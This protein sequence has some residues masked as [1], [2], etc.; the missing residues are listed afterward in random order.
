MFI[1]KIAQALAISDIFLVL[2]T[3]KVSSERDESGIAMD[4]FNVTVYKECRLIIY[5]RAEIFL[6]L[7]L[8]NF[9]FAHLKCTDREQLPASLN[10]V[11][12]PQQ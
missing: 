2:S 12:G 8:Q 6:W 7:F 5:L 11:H 9:Q 4:R 3:F 1:L 10:R